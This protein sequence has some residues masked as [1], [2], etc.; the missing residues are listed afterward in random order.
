MASVKKNFAYQSVYQIL[1]MILP[2]VT[3][4]YVAR[5]LGTENNGIFSYTYTA[6]NYFVVFAMLG[7]EQYGNRS[8]ATVR[9]SRAETDKVFSQLF[10]VHAINSVLVLLIYAL[11]VISLGGEYS[12]FFWIQGL[13]V[14]SALLDVNWFFFGIEQFKVTV[15]RN[16]IIKLLTVAAV[17]I[18]VRTKDDLW[19][20][21]LIMSGGILMSQ[22]LLW[23]FIPKYVKFTRVLVKD[24]LRHIKPLLILFIALIAA[25]IYRMIDKFMLGSFGMMNDLGAYEYA[26]KLIRIPLSLITALGTVML[27]KM[28][29]LF[30]KH[31]DKE[32]DSMLEHSSLFVVFLA[33]AMSFG[34]AAISPE[35]IVIFLGN[36]YNET[37]WLMMILCITLPIIGFNNFVRTQ[38]LIPMQ[39][40]TV[41]TIAVCAG[42]A[43]NVVLN[44]FLIPWLSARGAAIATIFSYFAVFCFQVFPIAKETK[45]RSYLRFIPAFFIFGAI[46][47]F[48]VR[49]IG[50]LMGI[51][52][53]T[54]I[55]E[56]AAGGTVYLILSVLYLKLIK[57]QLVKEYSD[58]FMKPF[59]KG[60][61]SK[62]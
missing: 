36:E 28:S 16:V 41:Y 37:I 59:R 33:F 26:D 10:V 31:N 18:F 2:L 14:L 11:Y 45:V 60:K 8:I 24:C 15:T 7:L 53:L 55:I 17:F 48:A 38:M 43:V 58:K 25:H 62:K 5:V 27:S 22:I 49:V 29:H 1:T 61:Y 46:M 39:K 6:A 4:P 42:A 50:R 47:F 23:G 35:F 54:V 3:A 32:I 12:L 40:D 56:I 9:D 52:I 34:L 20:Y 19:I 30:S 51:S 57:P 21:T 13:Y 44:L